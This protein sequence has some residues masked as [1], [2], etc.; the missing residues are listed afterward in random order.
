MLNINLVETN[1]V[2]RISCVS[3]N[4]VNGNNYSLF[5]NKQTLDKCCDYPVALSDS[6]SDW[7][8]RNERIKCMYI[9]AHICTHARIHGTC[10]Q[11]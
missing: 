5:H 9:S 10:I 3:K 2:N 6:E 1:T 8:N 11:E 4:P 7:K